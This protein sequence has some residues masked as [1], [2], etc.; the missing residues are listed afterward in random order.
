MLQLPVDERRESP[1]RQVSGLQIREGGDAEKEVTKNTQGYNTKDVLKSRHLRCV[2]RSSI[3]QQYRPQ[4]HQMAVASPA[5]MEPRVRVPLQQHEQQETGQSVGGPN[6]NSLHLKN[7][8]LR[9]VAAVQQF[10]TEFNGA[11]SEEEKI[12]A[13]TKKNLKSHEAKWPLQLIDGSY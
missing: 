10:M 3:E 5:M 9:I 13:I 4:T 6:V 7:S 1:F 11:V 8:I 2:L 12:V